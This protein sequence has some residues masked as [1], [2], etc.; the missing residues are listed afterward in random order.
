MANTR[1]NRAIQLIAR[2]FA[3]CLGARHD[4]RS[5]AFLGTEIPASAK[6]TEN[7][8]HCLSSLKEAIN[9]KSYVSRLCHLSG[10]ALPFGQPL[11]AA[12]GAANAWDSV[13]PYPITLAVLDRIDTYWNSLAST[14][15]AAKASHHKV[16]EV[17]FEGP[18]QHWLAV[19]VSH[20][21]PPYEVSYELL[22]S[23]VTLF[24]RFRV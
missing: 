24:A 10:F 2:R 1:F 17:V 16:L 23:A 18:V 7:S 20:P 3:G 11:A 13:G 5:V 8:R 19:P 21:Q 4:V 6:L 14:P 12:G 9:A 15:V 22:Q